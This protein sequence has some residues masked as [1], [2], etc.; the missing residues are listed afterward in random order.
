MP[1]GTFSPGTGATFPVDGRVAREVAI[2]ETFTTIRTSAG[3]AA[4][5]GDIAQA[6]QII[7]SATTDQFAGLER[8]I[9]VFD[10]TTIPQGNVISAGTIQFYVTGTASALAGSASIVTAAPANTNNLVA[11]DYNIANWTMTKQATDIAIG[12]IGTGAYLPFV[13]NATGRL[14]VKVAGTTIFGLTTNFDADN[15]APVWSSGAQTR[16]DMNFADGVND[17]QL[18]VTY[19]PGGRS[20]LQTKYW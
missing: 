16:L 9:F 6:C 14:T 5:T 13:L 11:G 7:C 3:D 8:S 1:T 4:A 12:T 15:S 17:P 20:G 18:I 2:N 10:T 19:A